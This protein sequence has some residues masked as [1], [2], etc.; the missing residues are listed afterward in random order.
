MM[1]LLENL[2]IVL[3]DILVV[4]KGLLIRLK[5]VCLN[6]IPVEKWLCQITMCES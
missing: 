5:A 4:F 2:F 1:L 3:R 6:D